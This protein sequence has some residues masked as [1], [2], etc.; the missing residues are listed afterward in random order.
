M[1]ILFVGLGAGVV[2]L[3]VQTGIAIGERRYEERRERDRV[4]E[5]SVLAK[6]FAMNGWRT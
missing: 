6:F 2:A 1:T 4:R 3:A 5:S